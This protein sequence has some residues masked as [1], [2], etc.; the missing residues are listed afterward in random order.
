MVEPDR[1]LLTVGWDILSRKMIDGGR[2]LDGGGLVPRNRKKFRET[3]QIFIA[4]V[5]ART[6][7]VKANADFLIVLSETIRFK[8]EEYG[9]I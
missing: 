9:R 8:L 2:F 1:R 6:K 5:A 3:Y 4:R 7:Q